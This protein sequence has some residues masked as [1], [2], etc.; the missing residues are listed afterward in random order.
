[1]IQIEPEVRDGRVYFDLSLEVFEAL[2]V[3]P[4]RGLCAM[5]KE[6]EVI[7]TQGSIAPAVPQTPAEENPLAEFEVGKQKTYGGRT[8]AYEAEVVPSDK[9]LGKALIVTVRHQNEG[10]RNRLLANSRSLPR[11][12]L[13]GIKSHRKTHITARNHLAKLMDDFRPFFMHSAVRFVEG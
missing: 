11:L 8:P 6:G 10:L 5:A 3:D 9:R 13:H 1:M 12:L 2:G 7:L 4:R